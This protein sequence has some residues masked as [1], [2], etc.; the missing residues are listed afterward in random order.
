[1]TEQKDCGQFFVTNCKRR[2]V[3]KTYLIGEHVC[4]LYYSHVI[5]LQKYDK[6]AIQHP[7]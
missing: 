7:F 1:M 5:V 3:C 4:A 6:W 2:F